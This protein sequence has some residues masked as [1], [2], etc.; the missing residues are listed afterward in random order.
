M[1]EVVDRGK[2]RTI[3]LNGP[4]SRNALTHELALQIVGAITGGTSAAA[5]HATPEVSVT[6]GA[7]VFG[8]RAAAAR[9]VLGSTSKTR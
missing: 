4:E 3:T 9:S 7:N 8:S 2:V 1:I 5:L 6:R